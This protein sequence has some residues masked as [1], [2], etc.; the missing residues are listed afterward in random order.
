MNIV[1]SLCEKSRST[2]PKKPCLENLFSVFINHN[3]YILGDDLSE[4]MMYFLKSY[5]V[6]VDNQVRGKD[7]YML[8]KFEFCRNNFKSDDIVYMVEDDYMHYSGSDILFEEGLQH[9]DYVTLYDHPDKYSQFIHPNPELTDVG[10]NTVVFLTK[11]SHWKYTNSTTGTFAFI[12]QTLVEDYDIWMDQ[13]INNIWGYDYQGFINIRK[14][15]RKVASCIPGRSSHMHS[16][17]CHTPFFKIT[18]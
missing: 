12:H 10:E 8:D 7:K 15:N 13:V 5:N 14:N 3:I 18:D 16:E 9:A 4:D 17:L 2:Y 1:L 11:S 6:T